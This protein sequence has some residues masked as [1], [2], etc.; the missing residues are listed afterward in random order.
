[1][2]KIISVYSRE[3]NGKERLFHGKEFVMEMRDLFLGHEE[4]F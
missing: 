4:G 2:Y 3:E 1:M